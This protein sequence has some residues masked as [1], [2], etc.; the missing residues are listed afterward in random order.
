MKVFSTLEKGCFLVIIIF[1]IAFIFGGIHSCRK[2]QSVKKH[3][4]GINTNIKKANTRNIT[5]KKKLK[6][7]QKSRKGNLEKIH[8]YNKSLDDISGKNRAKTKRKKD[9]IDKTINKTE[10]EIELLKKKKKEIDDLLFRSRKL[11]GL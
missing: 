8:Q 11:L 3:E 4:E 2:E 5:Q 1:I 7:F 6:S 9:K 10:K